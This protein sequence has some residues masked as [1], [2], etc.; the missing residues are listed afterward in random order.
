MNSNTRLEIPDG[1]VGTD[2][3]MLPTKLSCGHSTNR[4]WSRPA[5]LCHAGH[6]DLYH[7]AWA[8]REA[9]LLETLVTDFFYDP[10]KAPWLKR[11]W[12]KFGSYTCKGLTASDVH[13]HWRTML[14]AAVLKWRPSRSRQIVHDRDI[15]YTA[16][17]LAEKTGSAL[18]S[19]SY[20]AATAFAP[21]PGLP[22]N[23][24][25]FQMHPH[26][27]SVRKLLR[28]EL[29][30]VPEASLSLRW[31]HE[32]GSSEEHFESLC[33]E[34]LLAN[35]WMAAS[36][37]TARTLSENG[38]PP[39]RIH[40]VPYGVDPADFPARQAPPPPAQ[41]LR[42]VWVGN[43]VQRKGLTYL[44]DA[45]H[46]FSA[47]DLELVICTHNPV[48]GDLV[49][50]R[51]LANVKLLVGLPNSALVEQ[52]HA[53][54]LFVLPALLEGFGAV[55]LEAMSCGLPVLTTPNTGGPDLLEEGAT[56]FI[57]PTRN[58]DAIA[59]RLEWALANREQIAE[60]GRAAARSARAMT[61]ENFRAGV[62]TA[63]QSILGNPE[64]ANPPPVPAPST[65][66]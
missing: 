14:R 20:Y 23:R 55:I 40:V 50:R 21:G 7:V 54:D 30:R 32:V 56:G 41:P 2:S 12:P 44:L 46:R 4:A 3:R 29:E 51:N 39:N 25:L 45:V 34:P 6:R 10:R 59:E 9:N 43:L 48:E 57:V 49:R 13:L 1:Q 65:R 53:A 47:R 35:A 42:L 28:E 58:S 31:E 27:A 24:I 66:P 36:S 16:R 5:V 17:R 38:I 22:T 15:G 61:W 52:L 63:Y 18:F 62:V 33:Q 19:Y 8:L 64:P 26:P 37:F 60:M 11:L